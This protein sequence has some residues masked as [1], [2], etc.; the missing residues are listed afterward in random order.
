MSVKEFKLDLNKREGSG[1]KA[2]K[3]I[4]REGGIPVFITLMILGKVFLSQSIKKNF[5]KH[6]NLVYIFLTS[7]LAQ[8]KEMLFLNQFNIIQ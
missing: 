6:K 8:K 3:Q 1:K 7:V 2:S 4:R 5:L